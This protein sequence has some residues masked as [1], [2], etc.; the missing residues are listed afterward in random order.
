MCASSAPGPGSGPAQS[1]TH[2]HT[3]NRRPAPG[4]F[5]TTTSFAAY[6]RCVRSHTNVNIQSLQLHLF[7]SYTRR[8]VPYMGNSMRVRAQHFAATVAA[9]VAAARVSVCAIAIVRASQYYLLWLRLWRAVGFCACQ[10]AP[11]R[12]TVDYNIYIGTWLANRVTATPSRSAFVRR[13][14]TVVT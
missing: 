2:T 3:Q 13:C 8:T 6:A 14:A 11:A 12:A 7:K 1:N 4:Q 9:A 5:A 10:A